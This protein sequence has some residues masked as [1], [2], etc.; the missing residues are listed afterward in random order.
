MNP[1][2]KRLGLLSQLSLADLWHDRKVTLCMAASLVAVIAPLLLLFGLKHGVV[3][4]LQEELLS[5]P[6]NRFKLGIIARCGDKVGT[7]KLTLDDKPYGEY[8]VLALEEVPLAGFFGRL[9]DTIRLWF[10]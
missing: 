1:W 5:D 7:L 8:P 2:Y 4:Q 10:A 3:S 6:R 9:W